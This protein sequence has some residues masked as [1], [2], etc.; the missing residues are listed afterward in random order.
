MEEA[1]EGDE[2]GGEGTWTPPKGNAVTV[3]TSW[4]RPGVGKGVG[5]DQDEVDKDED[6]DGK[7][8]VGAKTKGLD[9]T[10]RLIGVG[11]ESISTLNSR[12]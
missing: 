9:V 6:D 11:S 8:V 2:L 1:P 7:E 12:P 5:N 3:L 10:A 4:Q